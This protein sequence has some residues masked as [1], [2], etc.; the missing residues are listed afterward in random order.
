MTFHQFS[1]EVSKEVS[2]DFKLTV[3]Q[4]KKLLLATIR[5]MIKLI[6]SGHSIPWPSFMNFKMEV[7]QGRTF[8]IPATQESITKP[9]R[10]VLKTTISRTFRNL[11]H[12]KKTY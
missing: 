4:T 12:A 9:N 11:I 2:K 10:F 8:Y 3:P 5:V 6:L 7:A 1:K